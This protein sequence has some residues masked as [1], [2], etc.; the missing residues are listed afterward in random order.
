MCADSVAP[1]EERLQSICVTDTLLTDN[2]YLYVRQEPPTKEVPKAS[3]F[4]SN[5]RESIRRNFIT[6]DRYK[7]LLSG[8]GMTIRLS[9]FSGI[10]GTLLGA[11]VCW[12]RLRRSPFACAFASLYIRIFRSL[13]VVVL[14]LVLDY[15]VLRKSGLGAFWICVITFSIEFSSYCAEIFRGGINAVPAGQLRAA[16]ALGFGKGLTFRY[17]TWPQALIHFLPA[18]SGQFI[19]TV[20]M[21]AVAGYISVTDLTKA[22]DIIR[23]RTYEAFFPLLLTSAV[24]LLL[25]SL[26]VTLLR[27]LEKRIDPQQRTVKKDIV[28]AVEEFR[29]ESDASLVRQ[30]TEGKTKETGEPLLKLEHLHKSFGNVTPIRDVNS[31]VYGGDVIAVIGPSGT[32]KSTLLNLINHLEKPDG[33][34]ILFEG[35]DTCAKGYDVNRMREQVGMVFQSFNLFSHLTIVENLMLAQT[36]LLKRSREEACR[37]SME[38]LHMVGL[39][40]KALSLPSQLSGGQ[41]QRA[42]IVRTVAMDPKI[43]LFDEPTSGTPEEIFDAPKKDKTRQFIRH[44]KVLE[45][46]VKKAEPGALFSSIEQFGVRHMISRRLT[47]RVMTV[48]DELCVRTILPGL[49]DGGVLRFVME[50]SDTDGVDLTVSYKGEDRNPLEGEDELSAVLLQYVCPDLHYQY[51]CGECVIKGTV[52]D[53]VKGTGKSTVTG[54]PR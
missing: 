12:L 32:G 4:F 33:G 19:A 1:S 10:F 49:E 31:T 36:L 39:A 44:M 25:C 18:Y 24:Y 45:T 26:L 42:A 29:P 46:D 52:K 35:K 27:S 51:D 16:T 20:K 11:A 14:L 40:D 41:Q 53:T 23:S 43:I 48:A 30:D 8:L 2:H 54:A 3:V 9:L 47:G 17:V 21:T 7:I 22:S 50:Y 15:V 6:E 13:P 34:T 37:K 28:K 38:L 5:I